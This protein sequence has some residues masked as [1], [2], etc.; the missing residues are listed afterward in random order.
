MAT[1]KKPAAAKTAQ[2]QVA[3][4]ME[5]IENNVTELFPM[6]TG[7]VP[8]AFRDMAEKGVAQ[9]RENYAKVKAAA[10]EATDVLEESFETA[11]ANTLDLSTATMDAAKANIDAGFAFM[12]DFMAVKSVSE[13]VELQTAF[14][15]ERFDASTAQA[16]D[17]QAK[18]T[19]MTEEA[20][21]PVKDAMAKSMEAFKAA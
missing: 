10:E 6:T 19:K 8:E 12:K 13:A 15:R 11:R 9:A 7:D 4:V 20:S 16:K 1:A 21:K 17:M 3:E 2:A 14:A 5:T 18:V